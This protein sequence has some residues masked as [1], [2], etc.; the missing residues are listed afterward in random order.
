MYENFEDLQ[1]Q[2]CVNTFCI[3]ISLIKDNSE[4]SFFF[5][6][7]L[8][9]L[10]EKEKYERTIKSKDFVE[11]NKYIIYL[12]EYEDL[13]DSKDFFKDFFQYYS[14]KKPIY[15]DVFLK[16]KKFLF[17]TRFNN[18]IYTFVVDCSKK[19]KNT[20][21]TFN[22]NHFNLIIRKPYYSIIIDHILTFFLNKIKEDSFGKRSISLWEFTC[23]ISNNEDLNE[24]IM[25]NTKKFIKKFSIFAHR[26]CFNFPYS[27][28]TLLLYQ[29]FSNSSLFVDDENIIDSKGDIFKIIKNDVDFC[30]IQKSKKGEKKFIDYMNFSLKDYNSLVLLKDDDNTEILLI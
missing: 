6:S 1:K 28:K 2:T 20:E 12:A 3:T 30:T 29:Y 21:S 18:D 24:H 16:H 22:T 11:S 14:T 9:Y 7:Y 27:I 10:S 15:I 26:L 25:N 23:Y 5:P 8:L 13:E 4:L 17:S 19:I